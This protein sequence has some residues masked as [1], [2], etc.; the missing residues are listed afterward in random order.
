MSVVSVDVLDQPRL[1]EGC[2]A[3]QCVASEVA[4]DME[5]TKDASQVQDV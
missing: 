4:A 5:K 1:V 3:A 2:S